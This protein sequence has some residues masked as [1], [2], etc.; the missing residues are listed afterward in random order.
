MKL[1]IPQENQDIRKS[2]R[3]KLIKQIVFILLWCTAVSLFMAFYCYGYLNAALGRGNAI[4][5]WVVL[6]VAPFVKCK[7]WKWFTDGAYEGTVIKTKQTSFTGSKIWWAKGGPEN[8]LRMYAQ[9]IQIRMPNGKE[10][11]VKLTWQEGED[12]PYYYEGDHVRRYRGTKFPQ[13][14]SDAPEVPRICVMCGTQNLPDDTVCG[15]CH[16]SLIDHRK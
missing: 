11:T 8:L 16:K 12:V 9:N 10:K 15:I 13:V 14:I 1:P 6:C 7:F 2:I 4:A 5:I 3:N